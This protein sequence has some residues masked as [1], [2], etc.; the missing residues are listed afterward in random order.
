MKRPV[1]HPRISHPRVPE[2]SSHLA[3]SPLSGPLAWQEAGG[4]SWVLPRAAGTP[5]VHFPSSSPQAAV[6]LREAHQCWAPPWHGRCWLH[7]NSRALPDSWCFRQANPASS[8]E[9]TWKITLDPGPAPAPGCPAS[10][11]LS[12]L[13]RP[14]CSLSLSLPLP[15][16][17]ITGETAPPE[18]RC[19]VQGSSHL[20]TGKL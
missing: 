9:V 14:S 10:F 19:A 18:P 5:P 2:H 4:W 7:S 11:A 3:A 20:P 8:A 15:H 13:L 1:P 12:S 16:C 17:F 6:R